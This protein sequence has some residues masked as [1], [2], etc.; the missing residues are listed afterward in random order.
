MN[1][2]KTLAVAGCSLLA[3]NGAADESPRWH[4]APDNKIVWTVDGQIPHEDHIE[5]SGKQVSV[6]L[7]YGVDCNG[8]FTLNKSMVWPL[9]RTIPNNTH[10]SLMRRYDWNPLSGITVNGRSFTN[11]KVKDITLKGMLTVKS[12][13]DQ[14]YYGQWELTR[15]YLPSA[16]LPV[17]VELYQ[18]V[19]TGKGNLSIEI[20]E[21]GFV[22]H[23]DPAKG[24]T[25]SYTIEGKLDRNGFFTL[26]PGD[27]LR[28]TASV[29]AHRQ[30]ESPVKIDAEAEKAKR[31]DLVNGWMDKLVL[32]TPDSVI[33]RMFAFSKIRACES[34]Y[35]TQGGPM[36]GPGG[37][38]YY[39]AIWAN[40]Q[41]EYIN[42]YFPFTGYEYGNASA[43]NSFRH[44]ARFMNDEWK[45][46]PS[47]IVA[48][49]LDIW[50]GVGDRGDAAMIAYGAS[51]YALAYGNREVA[52]ELWQ[53]ITWCLEYC[54][55]KLNAEGVVT[56][57]TDE[58]EN[59][60]PSGDANLCTSSLYY[61]ALISASYLA[62]E[63]NKGSK[64][65]N[66]YRSQAA[67]LRKNIEK[68]F[69]AKV[70]GFDTYAYY[71]GNDILR[72]W[73][74]I[75][76]TVGINERAQGTI[77]AL[78]SPRLWTENGLLTQAGDQT[79][80]DR[81]TLYAL[82]GVYAAG[83]TEKATDYL[84]RYSATRL[85]GEHV[86]YAIEAWPEG[87]QRHLSAESGLYGRIITEG[88]FGIRPVGFKEFIAT[89]R[90]P[91]AW[92]EMRLRNICAFGTT[93]DMEV[94]RLANG[95][96]QVSV[97]QKGKK[98]TYTVKDGN[99]INIKLM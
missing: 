15:E 13:F 63:L 21:D 86:P 93:F 51:R 62:K 84:H 96:L 60:F 24:V 17:L 82:R 70:E 26:Q 14:G 38:S 87:G 42:A 64:I 58:L 55:R 37:E 85:L 6:V 2:F 39:A 12:T 16:E 32:E 30:N 4:I 78:F 80:W 41:A 27:T 54:K 28:F 48:E 66:T 11:E 44:F 34:I 92:N 46:I 73:I 9:L 65:A 47:S 61:D 7:R 59:R 81:S 77:D 29:S 99:S 3:L 94:N 75:P 22:A 43:L 97:W 50:N 35:E 90:L 89:P 18:V 57:D 67:E 74:C 98:K 10:A 83:E 53:L 91:Q 71:K 19:N 52:E 69:G 79:F 31:M 76:L 36:H 72:S 68:Y 5:M 33:N 56:S 20:P 1:V 25:G 8:G 23:T 49:G 40:D 88:M 45:P 95:K